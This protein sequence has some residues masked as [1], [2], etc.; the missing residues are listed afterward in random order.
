MR[1]TMS[2]N[3]CTSPMPSVLIFPISNETRAPSSSRLAEMAT[4]ICL[5][6]SPRRGAGTSAEH[7]DGDI[8]KDDTYCERA[9]MPPESAEANVPLLT[10]MPEE[11]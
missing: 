11:M 5:N 2:M 9:H 8:M 1:L 3:S 6:I 10:R 7:E 4:R